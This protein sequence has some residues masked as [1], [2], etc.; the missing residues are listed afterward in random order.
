MQTFKAIL[1][2]T[3]LPLVGVEVDA[4]FYDHHLCIDAKDIHVEVTE[5]EVSVGGFEHN[6]FFLNWQ[7]VASTPWGLKP[8]TKGDKKLVM[9][10]APPFLKSQLV[11]WHH[12]RYNIKIIWGSLATLMMIGLFSLV[13]L[14]W[15]YDRVISWV[16]GRVSLAQEEQ[17][18][19]SVLEQIKAKGDILEQGLAVKAVQDIGKRLTQGSRYQYRWFIKKDN[20]I[21]ALALPG[22][23]VIVHS[24]LIKKADNPDELAAVLAH[25][26][27]HIEQQH[28][29]KNMIRSLGWAMILMVVLGDVSAPTAII[30]HQ[31]GNMYFS[32]DLEDEADRLGFQALM[33]AKITPRGMVTFFQKLEKEPGTELPKWISSH[34]ATSERI[35]TI[36]ELIKGH[37]CELC[38]PLL[39][40][41]KKIQSDFHHISAR[42]HSQS[43]GEI[44][45]EMSEGCFH[46][47]M[48][49]AG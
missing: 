18:G 30:I 33:Q 6:E 24:A 15:Q 40:D 12:Q 7:D 22:G 43:F 28:T 14:W 1:Y 5:I 4:Y 13:L 48:Y 32:R 23:I 36:E 44:Q 42:H 46:R 3:N 34:P 29:L 21:N 8:L 27:Q 2:G 25:E 9:D 39:L 45:V 17:L 31:I 11:K 20:M 49:F 16:A 35:K 19:N 37:P 10:S 26:V 47:S 38:Q 41:W